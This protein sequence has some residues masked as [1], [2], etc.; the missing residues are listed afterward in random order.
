[1]T[2]NP[3]EEEREMLFNQKAGATAGIQR[4]EDSE[5]LHGEEGGTIFK[6][7]LPVLNMPV[8]FNTALQLL[9]ENKEL[10]T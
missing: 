4:K 9:D 6:Y 5:L 2:Y 10:E 8:K 1:M 3:E 7:D